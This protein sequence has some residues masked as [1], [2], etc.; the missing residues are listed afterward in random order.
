M[1]SFK[2]QDLIDFLEKTSEDSWLMDKV[3]S[4][5]GK[6]NCIM[7]H[8]Y[9]FGAGGYNKDGGTST[10]DYFEEVW[11]TTYMIYPVNDGKNPKYQQA[12]PKQ[13]VLAYLKDLRDGKEKT[14]QDHW[15][16]YEQ[17]EKKLRI[18]QLTSI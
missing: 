16:D 7:G 8:I 2:L 14:T 11:A 6:K 15:K 4:K 13:R 17:E 18:T 9:A 5:D 1:D 3:R 10:Q 12:T